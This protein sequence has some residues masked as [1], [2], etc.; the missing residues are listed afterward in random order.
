[1]F[2]KI[3]IISA[4]SETALLET[5]RKEFRIKD[6]LNHKKRAE[7]LDDVDEYLLKI[8]REELSK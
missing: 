4:E 8:E 7:V 2:H 6:G 3:I 1:M 5:T